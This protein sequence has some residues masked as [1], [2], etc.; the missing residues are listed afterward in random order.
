MHYE[1]SRTAGEVWE[2][3]CA[4]KVIVARVFDEGADPE[5]DE[6]L[7][8]T[9]QAGVSHDPG[10]GY[11]LLVWEPVYGQTFELLASGPDDFPSQA[12][13]GAF[14]SDDVAM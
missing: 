12:G 14:P 13:G 6:P 2:A 7:A 8:V 10:G 5:S 3:A 11:V 1:A 4:G 9:S